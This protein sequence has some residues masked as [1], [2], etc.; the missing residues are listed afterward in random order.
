MGFFQYPHKFKELAKEA[1][2]DYTN[3]RKEYYM[4]NPQWEEFRGAGSRY[5][6][7]YIGITG[8]GTISIYAG[9]YKKED[10]KKYK[11]VLFLYDKQQ[12]LIGIKFSENDDLGDGTYTLNHSPKK[13]NAW[14]SATNFFKHY[15]YKLPLIELKGKYKPT[16]QEGEKG[17]VFI[18]D[19][20]SKVGS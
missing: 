19:L 16:K 14:I 13:D 20:K 10:I 11:K 17:T 12:Q 7:Y 4:E 5:E 9:F 8:N 2:N 18:V 6:T 3:N 1:E 15:E